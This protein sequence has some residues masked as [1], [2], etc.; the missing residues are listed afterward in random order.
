MK[1]ILL[2]VTA[3]SV[4]LLLSSCVGLTN[5]STP[6][7]VALNQ[8]NF[9]FVKSVSAE[10]EA[11]Y[12]FGIGGFKDRA[13]A[14]VV[15]KLRETAQLQ[16]N[17]ALADIR[18]KTTKKIYLGI[19][20]KRI[21][22]A[23]ASVVEFCDIATNT[24]IERENNKINAKSLIQPN[25]EKTQSKSK[26]KKQ[27][28]SSIKVTKQKI[29]KQPKTSKPIKIEKSAK[30]EKQENSIE[31]NF[32]SES[33]KES[34]REFVYQQLLDINKTLQSDNVE[35]I[36]DIEHKVKRI[37]KW[38]NNIG[39]TYPEIESLLKEIKKQLKD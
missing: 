30:V 17:Q 11:T 37:E 23:S 34:T 21:L 32:T 35:N 10:T 19:V 20:V 29:S 39:P 1:K 2:V 5:I 22:T 15:E 33:N 31:Q 27:K 16:S 26:G 6:Q 4:T 12:V 7:T 14:D 13:T 3:I 38:Y 28:Q 18:I 24:F 8:G 25:N 36:E 9:K